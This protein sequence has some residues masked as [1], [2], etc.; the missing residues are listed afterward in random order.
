MTGL[1]PQGVLP[2]DLQGKAALEGLRTCFSTSAPAHNNCSVNISYSIQSKIVYSVCILL[3]TLDTYTHTCVYI[4][5]YGCF[6][7]IYIAFLATSDIAYFRSSYCQVTSRWD[8]IK[9][10]NSWSEVELSGRAL[11]CLDLFLALREPEEGREK[12]R[13]R[14]RQGR[15]GENI[16]SFSPSCCY[17]K[18]REGL[19]RA[20]NL[21]VTE[22][23]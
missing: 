14:G 3:F 17:F 13:K 10:K 12:R 1:S 18:C 21:T 7:Y 8:C 4:Y 6:I 19:G 5:V 23:P 20:Q 15:M 16:N 2:G 22:C 9:K 11:A